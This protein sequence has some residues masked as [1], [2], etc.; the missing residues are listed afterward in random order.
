[1]TVDWQRLTIAMI[2]GDRREQEIARQAVATRA[3]VRAYAIPWP[4]EGI[5]GL[6]RAASIE[7]ALRDADIALFP[8][9]GIAPDG[10]LHAP[11]VEERVIPTREAL[12]GMRAP[13]HIILGWADANLKGHCEALGIELHEYEWDRELMLLRGPAII[14]GLIRVIVE[15]TEFTI[16]RSRVVQVGQGAI[17]ALATRT[18]IGLGARVHVAA[19]NPEQRAAAYAAGADVGDVDSLAGVLPEA[20][21]VL[22]TVPARVLE[23]PQLERI[24]PSALIVDMSAPPG[25]VD[26][27]VAR[28]LGLDTVWA[29]GLGN[30]APITVGRSQ[31]GG[32]RKRIE[33]IMAERRT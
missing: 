32:I 6:H 13:A 28:E 19:R 8:I 2:G 12:A 5:P 7:A 22:T 16:H 30:R 26:W 21:I 14:E 24:R 17:G 1:M 4:D 11:G 15:R 31:W 10:A 20:D 18:L 9:P 25:G 27:D 23:R 29:R 3:T 33:A